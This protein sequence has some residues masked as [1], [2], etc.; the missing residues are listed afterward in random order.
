MVMPNF[1]ELAQEQALCQQL[2]IEHLHKMQEQVLY[3]GDYQTAQ[4]HLDSIQLLLETL[5]YNQE[6]AAVS[7]KKADA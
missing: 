1:R 6:M 7:R 2:F 3:H 4:I 5:T